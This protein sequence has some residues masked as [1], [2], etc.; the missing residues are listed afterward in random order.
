MKK[1]APKGL[2]LS[3]S[4]KK[5]LL[6][7]KLAIFL[8]VFTVLQSMAGTVFSQTS[9]LTLNARQIKVEE[10]LL[11]IENQSNYVFLYN[12]DLIDV[13]KTT[14]INVK[15]ASVDEVLNM[16]FEGSNINYKLMGRQIVLS[17]AFAQQQKKV[18]G[19]V[20][21]ANGEPIP[22][23]AITVKGTT[24]GAITSVDGT[25]EL[26]KVEDSS[27]LVFSFVGL[28]SQEISASGKS[29][30][31]VVL[32]ED[33]TDLDEVIV[34]GYGTA[35]RQ[36]YSGSVSSVKME[37]SAISQLPNLNALESLKGNVAG[38]S[39]GATNTAGGQPSMEIRGQNSISGDNN[40][41]IVL[42]GVI[43]LG[44]LSDINP[45]D[46][47]TYD[48]LKDAVSAAA[49]GSRSANGVIAITTKKGKSGKPVITFNTSAGVQSWQ[50]QPVMMKGEE[51]IGVV[52]ARNKY[53]EGSTNW[54]KTG[55]LANLAAGSETVWLDQVTRTG[56]VQDYQIAVSGAA[57]DV[58]YYVSSSYNANKGI[59]VG[60][61]FSRISLLGKI[62]A[63][64]TSW[65]KIGLDAS[66]SRRDYSGFAANVGEAQ[67]MSPYGV[68]YRDDLGN[69]EKYPYTQSSMNPLWGVNDDTREN[70][71]IR[72]NYRLNAYAVI[73]APWVKGLNYR[74]NV[75]TNLDNNQS[76][77]FTNETYYIKEGEGLARYE[78]A[79]VVGFL[80][81]ANGNVDNNKTF[82]YVFDNILNYKNTFGKHSVEATAVA[83]RDYRRYEQV[84]ST[85]SD[86]AGNGNTTLGMWGLAKATIQK[87]N[88]N[89][90]ERA[91]I[92]YLGRA[93]YSFEDKYFFTG[94]YRRDGASV[95]G[96]NK[97]WGNFAA[98]GAAW[99][100]SNEEFLKDYKPLNSLKLKVSWGQN[101]NQGTGPYGTLSTIANGTSGDIRYEYS[102]A[103]GKI[104]YGL[105]QNALGNSDLG[106]ESTNTWNTGFESV[107]L[108]SRIFIDLDT[109][110]SKTTDQ[111]FV[112]NIPVMTGFKTIKTS[113]GQVNNNG[114]EL[115][116]RT[117]NIKTQDLTWNTSVT[118][119]QN[120][121]KL[122]KLYGDDKD[123][124]GIE[125]DDIAN[126]LFIGKSLSAIY[127]YEQ[128][129]IV[130][131][132]DTEYKTL[133]GAADGAPKY[134][135][136]DNIAGITAADRKILG[137][138]KE[139]FRLNM[140]NSVTYKNFEL[141][142]M[143]TGTFGGNG[144]FM[145][146]NTAAYMTSG[147]GRFNDNMTSKPYWTS[148]NKSNIYPSAYFAGDGRFLALQSRG[149]VRFQDVS[150]SYSFN[151][152][153]VK[154]AKI[155]TLKVFFSAKNLAT[156]TNWFGGDPETGTPVRENT[157]PVPSTYSIGANISF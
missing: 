29:T 102:N 116:V 127:G 8:M 34:I 20:T 41:L 33:K 104:N 101:G 11:Q 68:M 76:G 96:V 88:M 50:N 145:K 9:G 18:T 26:P 94:S 140:S 111:I 2:S 67:T 137:Y 146:A 22:G 60:D 87:V 144:Y 134:K 36:D 35:R 112:R 126:S 78:P 147:T 16:L 19:K 4:L 31:N 141:Y 55:E 24:N 122:V 7:M 93:S 110:F 37:G 130:Q 51:W 106:W 97:K 128:D 125:D 58:N 103:Q 23:V 3:A 139:N 113:M 47:A 10:I 5:L 63:S 38:L 89:I 64:I 98:A 74:I 27:I 156:I 54:M 114:I 45:N 105:Y 15:S 80:A 56:V 49:Y 150:L 42:D 53:A 132:E 44:S 91:N 85:G 69:L 108:N 70:K 148:E 155:N 131:A 21:D 136:L 120:R 151:Q 46:I 138:G 115:T 66:Y 71:D 12:K 57:Q 65:L 121:N 82:S 30:I 52:N 77:N 40:P 154:A 90:D 28:K 17:P 129:G 109:Y 118:F 73:D 117:V 107:W 152:S 6:I 13:E 157:F 86:F 133:T 119:W 83:T 48:I 124:D 1:I 62:N 39:I 79:T 61:D 75:L 123:G 32:E 143:I 142:A 153:W 72:N 14:S 25:Y 92:G 149:F 59:V 99:K 84:N 135:D 43:Y 100:I 95:F 81:T